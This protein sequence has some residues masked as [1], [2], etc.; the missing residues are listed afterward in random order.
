MIFQI[1]KKMGEVGT[2]PTEHGKNKQSR[3]LI[4]LL[5]SS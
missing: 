1:Y 4:C 3:K 5:N 2:K